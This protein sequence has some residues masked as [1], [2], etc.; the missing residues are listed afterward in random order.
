MKIKGIELIEGYHLTA[1]EKKSIVQMI[2]IGLTNATN[3]PNT[4]SYNVISGTQDGKEFIFKIKVGSKGTW[5]IGA[6]VSWKFQNV[7][8]KT[9][10]YE[11]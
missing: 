1:I 11:N 10:G 5:T 7:T 3:R 9:K 6:N 8:V 2:N 4:K